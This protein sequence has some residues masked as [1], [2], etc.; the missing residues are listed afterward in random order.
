[1]YSTEDE[2]WT[3]RCTKARKPTKQYCYLN[4]PARGIITP[5]VNFCWP[6]GTVM[7]NSVQ[8]LKRVD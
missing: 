6:L 3:C 4:N 8:L 1:M 2:I 5:G 7:V